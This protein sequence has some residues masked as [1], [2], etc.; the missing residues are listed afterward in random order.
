MCLASF[1]SYHHEGEKGDC[2]IGCNR[3][4]GKSFH[5]SG[6]KHGGGKKKKKE[7]ITSKS[8]NFVCLFVLNILILVDCGNTS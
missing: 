3:F 1:N 8:G 7:N 6:G 2:K 5:D 4:G